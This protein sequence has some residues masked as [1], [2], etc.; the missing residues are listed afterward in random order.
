MD[1]FR[2]DSRPILEHKKLIFDP[3]R[4]GDL[5]AIDQDCDVYKK[6]F[7]DTNGI[8]FDELTIQA[9]EFIFHALL[10]ILE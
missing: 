10:I 7:A 9:L 4:Y 3:R 2:Q 1:N 5:V 8:E 6:Q